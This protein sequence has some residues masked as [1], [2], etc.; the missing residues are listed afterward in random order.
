VVA[1][2]L[3]MAAVMTGVGLALILA[4]GRID[5]LG[6]DST[7]GRARA[8]LPL[9]AA[10]LVFGIGLYLTVQAVGPATF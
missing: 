10:C 1:F 3:G 2:G 4:R 7:L 6:T 8:W 5:G 9:A